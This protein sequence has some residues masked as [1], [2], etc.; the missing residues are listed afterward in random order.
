MVAP[1]GTLY[2]SGAGEQFEELDTLL[3]TLVR[4]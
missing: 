4:S 3:V 2:T 1:D